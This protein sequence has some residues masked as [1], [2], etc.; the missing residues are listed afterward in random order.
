MSNTKKRK[1]TTVS[2]VV[3][4]DAMI[5]ENTTSLAPVVLKFRGVEWTFKG[6]TDAP[7]HLFDDSLDEANSALFFLN[8]MLADGQDF[9]ADVTLREAT[10]I[11][12]AY[13]RSATGG[14]STG[15]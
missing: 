1:P 9:P 15:E 4:V 5:A 10:T 7:L 12:N 2:D 14:L 3:D 11:V 6:I 13:T 8:T